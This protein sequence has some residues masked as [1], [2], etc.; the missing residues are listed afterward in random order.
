VGLLEQLGGNLA[1]VVDEADR[2]V[3]GQ[4]VVDR[5]KIHVALVE[6]VVIQVV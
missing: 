6:Q 2:G 4:R 3:P 1:K 5:L